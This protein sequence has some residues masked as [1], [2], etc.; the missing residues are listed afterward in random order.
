MSNQA[1]LYGSAES[2]YVRFT[3]Y[4]PAFAGIHVPSLICE[5]ILKNL[6]PSFNIEILCWYLA[7]DA[8]PMQLLCNHMQLLCY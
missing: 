1:I 7:I 6:F 8:F 5:V 2:L 4:T 3:H